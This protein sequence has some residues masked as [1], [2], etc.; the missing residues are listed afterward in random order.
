MALINTSRAYQR[1]LALYFARTG[2]HPVDSARNIIQDIV[3]AVLE[4]VDD[5]FQ[6]QNTIPVSVSGTVPS[7][8]GTV[9]LTGATT[10]RGNLDQ[11]S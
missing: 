7:G 6:T 5:H 10:T 4:E 2:I 8:G 9:T 11:T 1:A 3:Q